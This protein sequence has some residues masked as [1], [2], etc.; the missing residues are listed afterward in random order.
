MDIN[1]HTPGFY[2]NKFCYSV[3]S[4]NAI[5]YMVSLARKYHFQL[6]FTLQPEWDEAV[7]AGL[8]SEHLAAEK[9]YLSQFTDETY[10]HVVDQVPKTL[11]NKEQ[12]Q[13]PNHL[14][15]GAEKIYM[16]EIVNGIAAVQN[17]LTAEQAKPLE[18]TSISL[19]KVSYQVGD[20]PTVTVNVTDN[21][22]G[23]I[24]DPDII[25]SVSCLVKPSGKID[26]NW[27]ARAPAVTM[28]LEG[29]DTEEL[30]LPLTE[31]KLYN[32]GTYDLVIFLRQDEGNLSHET[33]IEIPKKIIVK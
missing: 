23:E 3:D 20:Q 19:D 16:E 33:R 15:H 4:T 26:A 6:Y 29:S 7:N 2:F 24:T 11:F 12:M 32:A 1:T 31:G 22:T 9:K 27:V 14:W 8:R 18:I 13:N 5:K 21:E 10:V 30:T 28:T 17:D 25:G